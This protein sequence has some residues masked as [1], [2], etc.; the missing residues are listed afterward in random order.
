VNALVPIAL[1][2]WLP[3][4]VGALG[5]WPGARTLALAFVIGWLLL[6]PASYKLLEH[7]PAYSKPLAIDLGLLLAVFLLD[8]GRLRR[9]RFRPA[10]LPALV[11]CL[12]PFATSLAA[13]L[14]AWDG[15]SAVFAQVV[16]WGVPY[17]L[18]RLYFADLEALRDLALAIVVGGLLYVPLCLVEVLQGPVLQPL[19]YGYSSAAPDA[20][21]R[22]G[23]WRPVVFLES[24]LAV[25]VY[26]AAAAVTGIWMWRTGA[27]R[28][29]HS[30]AVPAAAGAL[31]FTVVLLKS[32]NGWLLL[33][34]GLALPALV[35]RLRS[36]APL[37]LVG[38]AI[39]VYVLARGSGLWTGEQLVPPVQALL[40]PDRAASLSFRLINDNVIA[41]DARSRVLLG[42]GRSIAGIENPYTGT[43]AIP[44][45]LWSIWFTQFGVVGLTAVFALFLV[46][47]ARATLLTTGRAWITPR[48][49]PAA[50]LAV[51]LLLGL[52][53]DLVNALPD[54]LFPLVA[55][56]LATVTWC[57]SS[58]TTQT[59]A[60]G[61]ARTQLF[62]NAPATSPE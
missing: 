9:A 4:S 36:T 41:A 35:T 33:L 51:V 20:V 22:F 56:G 16:V 42:W 12:S 48:I 62:L 49:A 50:A 8:R 13:G 26:M 58:I 21:V 11:L 59:E 1:F 39:V 34:L 46:P 40:G 17:L 38:S 24:G 23:G 52:V 55:G 31:L 44:D 30:W 3:V 6:P 25:A 57:A 27:A 10:D 18:G 61:A 47:V 60:S 43:Y 28:W 45:S 54:P 14:G 32:V 7:V 15:I 2:G 37:L 29:R 53:D 19:L 5:R